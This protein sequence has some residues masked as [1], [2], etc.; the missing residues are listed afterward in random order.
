[1]G[2]T[3]SFERSPCSSRPRVPWTS[4]RLSE[5]DWSILGTVNL[6]RFVSGDQLE[7]LH[8]DSLTGHSRVVTRGRV[9]NRLLHWQLLTLLPRRVGGALRG[10]A[11]S[12][13]A[14]GPAGT[15]L[16]RDKQ[17]EQGVT[18]TVRQTGVPS[19][20]FVKHSLAVS[21]LYAELHDKAKTA[22]ITIAAFAT[23]PGCHWPDGLGGTVQ[24]DAYAAL[25]LGD[26]RE[27]FWI[28]ADRATESLPTMIRKAKT[29]LDFV[30]RGQLGPH[31]VIPRV[32][33][34]TT[35]QKRRDELANRLARLP[36]PADELFIISVDRESV[37][38]MLQSLKE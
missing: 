37:L 30:H 7:R 9:L 5:R 6:L 29:Y 1:M 3:S 32:L 19:E 2:S 25:S 14:L 22:G 4:D 15:R 36:S 27:H 21:E 28:E 18:I 31:G 26:V 20:R 17:A 23:E 33:I 11:G 38:L 35:S 12:V 16:L 34:S 13:Y 10:S 8:F 24:P